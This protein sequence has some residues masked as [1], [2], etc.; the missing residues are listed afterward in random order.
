LIISSNG[1]GKEEY[2]WENGFNQPSHFIEENWSRGALLYRKSDFE[3]IGEFDETLHIYQDWERWL[4][5]K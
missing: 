2:W 3:E 1:C 5:Q 4:T